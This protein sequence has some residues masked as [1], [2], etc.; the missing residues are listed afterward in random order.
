MHVN[1]GNDA[2]PLFEKIKESL[3][4]VLPIVIIVALL[5]L[6]VTPVSTGYLLAFLVGTLMIVVGMGLFTLGAET[7][8]TV[9]GNRIGSTLTKSKNL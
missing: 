4:S 1:T 9:I 8:M 6:I 2:N 5:C 7:S 3:V